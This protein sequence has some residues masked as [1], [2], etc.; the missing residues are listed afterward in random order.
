MSASR[1][2]FPYDDEEELERLHHGHQTEYDPDCQTCLFEADADCAEQEDV[3]GQ[4]YEAGY[5]ELPQNI[6]EP[7]LYDCGNPECGGDCLGVSILTGN[8]VVWNC[9]NKKED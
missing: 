8:Q 7:L 9:P 4:R 3:Y 1:E 5:L 6:E 2:R